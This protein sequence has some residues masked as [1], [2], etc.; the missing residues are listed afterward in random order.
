[1]MNAVVC[2]ELGLFLIGELFQS[3]LPADAKL[4]NEYH[5]LLVRAG[6][7]FCRPKARCSNCPLEN[8]PHTLD[9]ECF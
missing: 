3:N 4:F 2:H 9:P 6:K 5:A 1:M 8:L 7:E